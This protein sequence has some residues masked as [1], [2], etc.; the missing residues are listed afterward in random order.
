VN[1]RE[2]NQFIQAAISQSA[3]VISTHLSLNEIDANEGYLR[4]ELTLVNGFEFIFLNMWSPNPPF[5]A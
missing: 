5:N 3:L 2:Y 1:A 4:G